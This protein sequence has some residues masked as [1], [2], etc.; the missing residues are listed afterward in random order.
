M[1]SFVMGGLLAGTEDSTIAS[2][3]TM[4]RNVGLAFQ[5]QDDVL[6]YTAGEQIMG[7]STS[8]AKNNKV[9]F[10]NLL[11]LKG[12]TDVYT[13]LYNSAIRDIDLMPIGLNS[14]KKII[15]EMRNRRK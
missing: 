14:V 2:L 7:K 1:A 10:Y 11:G 3:E 6:D 5:I 12:C 13:K 9:T 15:L 4:G 8:D